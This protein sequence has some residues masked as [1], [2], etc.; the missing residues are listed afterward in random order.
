MSTRSSGK[1]EHILKSV[2]AVVTVGG[3]LLA[4]VQFL[5]SQSVDAQKPYL[6]KK[7]EWCEEAANTAAWISV[8]DPEQVADKK[9]R[10]WEL[11]WGVMGLVENQEVTDAMIAFGRGLQGKIPP[12]SSLKQLSLA[13]AHAC[14]QEL[15]RDWS[16]IWRK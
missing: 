1:L 9:L 8:R 2:G 6:E 12:G 16:P 3:L 7:L 4:L 15:A 10:F 5:I 14:R 13:I 11:Y